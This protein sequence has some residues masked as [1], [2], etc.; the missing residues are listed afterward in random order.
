MRDLRLNFTDNGMTIDWKG[1]VTD[2]QSV[3]QGALVNIVNREGSNMGFPL[4]GTS[5]VQDAMSG[6]GVSLLDATHTANFAAMTTQLFLKSQQPDNNPDTLSVKKVNL[7]PI[8][9]FDQRL[10]LNLFLTFEDDSRVGIE[11]DI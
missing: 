10:R 4:Q 1:V 2:Q 11:R 7:Q 5:L 3:G 6:G 9:F 8:E